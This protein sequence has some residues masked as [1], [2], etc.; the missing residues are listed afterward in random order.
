MARAPLMIDPELNDQTPLWRYIQYDKFQDMIRSQKLF[1]CRGDYFDDRFEGSFTRKIK[2][3]IENA[4]TDNKLPTTYYEFRDQI[5]AKVFISCW[6]QNNFENMAMWDRYCKSNKGAAITTTVSKIRKELIRTGHENL[7][8]FNFNKILIKKV[9]YIDHSNNPNINI[10][11]YANVFSYKRIEYSDENEVR[12]IIDR[13]NESDENI[14]QTGMKLDI[15][16][17]S[18]LDRIVV[19]PNAEEGFLER[20]KALVKTNK[21]KA[22]VQTSKLDSQPI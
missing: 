2:R 14:P 16:I 15:R 4:I 13:T 5:R 22:K 8:D 10:K 18:L 11:P 21:L 3:L 1:L 20:I 12:I 6:H 7:F 19:A 17:N 9:Q